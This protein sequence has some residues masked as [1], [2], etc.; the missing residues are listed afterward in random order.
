MLKLQQHHGKFKESNQLL[1][2][3]DAGSQG[4]WGNKKIL[5]K[6]CVDV[7]G[8]AAVQGL[9]KI[10]LILWGVGFPSYIM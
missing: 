4:T 1:N 8:D 10:S 6:V 9:K 5:N 7:V 2:N 3:S